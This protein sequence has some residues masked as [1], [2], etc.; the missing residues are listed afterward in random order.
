MVLES[1]FVEYVRY[2]SDGQDAGSRGTVG[3]M[4]LPRQATILMTSSHASTAAIFNFRISNVPTP[5]EDR[6]RSLIVSVLRGYPVGA[7][8]ALDTRN[9]TMRFRPRPRFYAPDTG[10]NPG[11]LLL[12]GQQRLTT[13][14]HCFRG[15]GSVDTTDFRSKKITRTFYVDL[16]KAISEEIMPD[17]AVFA[18]NQHG[19]LRSHFAP[20]IE[21]ALGPRNRA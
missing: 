14:Y 17:E 15:N 21:G 9:E 11:L 6:I 16:H 2:I 5:D 13:L 3:T 12:D 1:D 19:E 4:V 7:L 18:V 20:N 10:V 8:M